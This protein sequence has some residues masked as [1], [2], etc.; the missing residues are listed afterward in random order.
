MNK[1]E[2]KDYVIKTLQQGNKE[3]IQ[4]VL[5]RYFEYLKTPSEEPLEDIFETAKK[6]SSAS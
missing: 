1:Q 5:K 6:I 3:R 4:K 2:I